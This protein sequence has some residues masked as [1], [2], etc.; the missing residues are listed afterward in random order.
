MAI[1]FSDVYDLF[2]AQIDDYELAEIDP[3]EV[4]IIIEKYLTNSLLT[5]Q[6][7][8]IDFM[9]VDLEKKVFNTD[10]TLAEKILV[11]KAMKLE[12]TREKKYSEELMRK[13][14]GDRDYKAVQGVD[15]LKQLTQVENNLKKEIQDLIVSRSYLGTENYGELLS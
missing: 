15:Y 12:W 5:L 3:E 10:L 2:L 4:E 13:S 7:S 8:S 6:E 11:S 1:K 14:I 9:D